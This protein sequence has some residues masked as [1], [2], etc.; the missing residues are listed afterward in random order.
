LTIRFL[1]IVQLSSFIVANISLNRVSSLMHLLQRSIVL[2]T[3]VVLRIKVC[4]NGSR[5][6]HVNNLE[7]TKRTSHST[8]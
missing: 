7:A 5:A 1:D 2:L 3:C 8:L 4:L 6:D